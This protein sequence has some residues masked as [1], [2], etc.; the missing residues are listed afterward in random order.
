MWFCS[1]SSLFSSFSSSIYLFSLSPFLPLPLPFR[2]F[3]CP[4]PSAC[5]LTF[6]SSSLLPLTSSPPF[7]LLPSRR[8]LF[9]LLLPLPSAASFFSTMSFSS[10][11]RY[12]R[13]PL[14]ASYYAFCC[15]PITLSLFLFFLPFVMHSLLL[16]LPSL[17]LPGVHSSYYSTFHFRPF[18]HFS[19]YPSGSLFTSSCCS[20]YPSSQHHLLPFLLLLLSERMAQFKVWVSQQNVMSFLSAATIYTLILTFFLYV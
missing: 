1:T 10:Y 12:L 2:Y 19:L 17:P 3:L 8:L 16:L 4:S 15:C 20:L 13:F 7:S 9:L 18:R 6:S 11:F 14:S 5:F